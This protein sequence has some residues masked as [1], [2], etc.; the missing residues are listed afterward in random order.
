MLLCSRRS[1]RVR[2]LRVSWS[3]P[4]V[5]YHKDYH[6]QDNNTRWITTQ[7]FRTTTTREQQQIN[8]D[9]T[10]SRGEYF[11]CPY[12]QEGGRREGIKSICRIRLDSEISIKVGTEQQRRGIKMDVVVRLSLS[13]IHTVT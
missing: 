7:L 2:G 1:G 3:I 9:T 12:A 10:D 4:E 13:F 8:M 5:Q 11:A 6:L